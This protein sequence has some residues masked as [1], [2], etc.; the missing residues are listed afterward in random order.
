MIINIVPMSVSSA[1]LDTAPRGAVAQSTESGRLLAQAGGRNVEFAP[2]TEHSPADPQKQDVFE[3]REQARES[4]KEIEQKA[5]KANAYF[6]ESG[7]HLAFKVSEQ[8]GRIIVHVIE[9][10][11]GE[12]VREIP[13]DT[14][15]R[16]S[17]RVT[18]I[19]GLL[20]E[21]QG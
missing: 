14:L 21:A 8:T 18:Q 4:A 20:F 5:E 9:S 16:F 11:S 12:I 10:D 19:K 3:A 13:P 7:T 1:R 17:D 6:Q 2:V 15:N